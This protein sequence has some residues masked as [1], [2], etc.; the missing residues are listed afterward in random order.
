MRSS[1]W[2]LVGVVGVLTAGCQNCDPEPEPEPELAEGIYAP[3]GEIIPT[4]SDAERA[5][6]ERGREVAL[7]VFTEEDGLGPGF[8]VTSCA[9]CHEKPGIGGSAGR[10][11]NFLL[12][13][14]RRPNGEQVPV[15]MN[16]VQHQYVTN[17]VRARLAVGAN[18]IATR[19]PIPF[20]GVGLIA[21]LSENA[22][23]ANEDTFDDDGDGISGKVNFDNGFVGR[24]GRK[25]Q[26]ASIEGFI[27]GPINNHAGITSDPLPFF[28]REQLPLVS[29]PDEAPVCG[30]FGVIC[31]AQAAAPDG[32]PLTDT[33][34]VPDPEL[35][36]DDLFDL[37]AFSMLLA[38][39]QPEPLTEQTTR[40]KEQLESIGCTTCHVPT[41]EGPRGLIPLYSD[42]L[43]H[44]MGAE[45]AD[46]IVQMDADGLEFRTQPLWGLA[47]VGPYL[48]DGRADTLDEAIR[49]HGGEAL[50]SADAYRAL[51]DEERLALIEFLLSLGGRGQTSEGLVPPDAP[52]AAPTE[53]TGPR[54]TLDDDETA[55]F[56]RGRTAFDRESHLS[57]GLGPVFNGDSCRACHFQ[58]GI[59]GGG[60]RDVDVVRYA[61]AD[62]SGAYVAPENGTM[63]A[64]HHVDPETR[65]TIASAD[66]VI[67]EAR[68][69]PPLF[70]IGLVDEV[71]ESAILAGADPDDTNGDGIRGIARI[72]DD[73]RVGRLGWKAQVPSLAEFA[74][75]AMGAELGH[76]VPTSTTLTF[77]FTA[78][79]DGAADPEV[80]DETLDDLTYFMTMLAPPPRE[81]L[82]EA[83]DE[84]GRALFA[85][86]GCAACHVP[87]LPTATTDVDI[88]SD[89]LL[90]DVM[91]GPS[92]TPGV[93]DGSFAD[94]VF[95]TSPLIGLRFS[96]PYLHDGVADTVTEAILLHA[97]DATPS[98]DA[99]SALSTAEQDAL[100]TFVH[101]L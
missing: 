62:G 85:A 75:D 68:Q 1:T 66:D 39:P 65:P 43:V 28:R 61:V 76:S 48:H 101:A 98:V 37:V 19:N 82:S 12:V 52:M 99:F 34:E 89:L 35:S 44:D 78:D 32:E 69:T 24:F 16:G 90:H 45:L 21:E 88:Y 73:G 55:R 93:P 46:G 14:Q 9:A 5:M 2:I 63:A 10:Y 41:L 25:S 8:N 67:F 86:V 81:P 53:I 92:Y 20:F 54:H 47:A 31:Q 56:L 87:T 57:G 70:G 17:G 30:P 22:I 77:G 95:R 51:P 58:G 79:D 96:A 27:R 38:A 64:L 100:V 42:L 13:Q 91:S 36:E 97:G 50:A 80:S 3:L 4:A 83:A 7:R 94:V 11:R 71:L 18:V 49:A 26:T 33:D 59:G 60:P 15:G 23:L 72:L 29:F 74:R 84:Q 40:G 6:F